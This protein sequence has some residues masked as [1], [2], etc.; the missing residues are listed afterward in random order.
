[1]Q[2]NKIENGNNKKENNVNKE[3]KEKNINKEKIIEQINVIKNLEED[4]CN[5]FEYHTV[6]R[7]AY[8]RDF[9]ELVL[10]IEE[11]TKS[12]IN[13]ILTGKFEIVD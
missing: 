4:G 10:F 8:D 3:I 7:I 12:Y 6:Q 11:H 2:E 13:L 1:M 5:M 9:F